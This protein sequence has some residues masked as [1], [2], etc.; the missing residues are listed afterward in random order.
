[1]QLVDVGR[2]EIHAHDDS[3]PSHV[4]MSAKPVEGLLAHLVVAESALLGQ[5]AT[6]VGSGEPTNR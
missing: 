3:R 1:M 4:Q 5:E 6:A 2:G